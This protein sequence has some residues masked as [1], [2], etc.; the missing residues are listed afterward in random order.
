M[1]LET[2]FDSLPIRYPELAGR[3][4]LVTGSSRG[5]GKGIALRLAREGMKVVINSRTAA[6]V[7]ATTAE[8]RS[9]GVEAVGIPADVGVTDDI[10]RLFREVVV[11]FGGVDLL[12][13]NAAAVRR[14]HFFD[15]DEPLLDQHLASNVKGP[16]LCS[17]RAAE[18][19]RSDRR[20]DRRSN[21]GGGIVH[22]SSVGGIRSHWRGLPYDVTKGA[23]DAMT[24]AMALELADFGVR[25]NAVAPGATRTERSAPAG[26]SRE[27]ALL[28]RIPLRRYGL[29]TEIGA[30]VAFLASPDAAYITGQV[31]YVDGGITA[32]L[33][34]RHELI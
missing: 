3:V 30:A 19:M 11:S 20:S 18:I 5:I 28:P 32:Q 6:V 9:L 24:R 31:L 22:I 16:Y 25:V 4:A 26:S 10:D 33:D 8:F 1:G 2:L 13:N 12:V 34:M 17:V 15:V 29:A 23:I 27:Q 14:E 21:H 7:Q